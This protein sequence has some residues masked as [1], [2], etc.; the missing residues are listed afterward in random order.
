MREKQPPK[1][2]SRSERLAAALKRNIG[3][4]KAAQLAKPEKK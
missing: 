4:R 3:R 2:P 1:P